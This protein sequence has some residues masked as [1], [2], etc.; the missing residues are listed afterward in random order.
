MSEELEM[1][2]RRL[3]A[4]NALDDL[5]N[6]RGMGTELVTVIIPPDRAIHDVRQQLSQE[7]GQASN[8]KSKQTKK[9]VSDAIES[10]ISS[11]NNMKA[12]PENGIVF[13]ANHIR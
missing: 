1:Q 9:H 3:K 2:Q 6:M 5:S 12:T 13:A 7:L 11:I 8:I 10:A 4:R